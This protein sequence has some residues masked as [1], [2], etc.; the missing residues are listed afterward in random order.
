MTQWGD[1]NGS[2]SYDASGQRVR[3][4]VNNQETWQIYGLSGELLA[5]YPANGDTSNPQKEYGYRNGQ[6]LVTAVPV[7][8]TRQ[9]F[10][11]RSNGGSA[12]A[13]SEI[14]G[15]CSIWPARGAI[16]G[17]RKGSY[18][19][20]NGGWADSSSGSFS[21]DWFQVDF[22][23]AKTI[24]ELD[25]F[26]LQD[27]YSNPTE[28]TEAMTFSTYGLTAY[29]VS[30]WNGSAWINIPEASVVANNKVWRKFTFSPITTTKIRVLPQAAV[31]NGFSRLT[32]VEAWGS[33]NLPT[34]TNV[35]LRSNGGV[36]TA[37]SEISA[38][39]DTWP[40]RGANDGDRKGAYW[41]GTGGWAD[42]SSGN[43]SND[44]LQIDFAG[45]KTI[46]EIDVFTLQ[47]NYANPIEPTDTTT[48]STYGLTAFDVSYWNGS[49]W[50]QIPETVVTGN[51]KVWRKLTF[52]AIT[53][54]KIR[55]FGRAA[56]DNGRSRIA[57]LEAWSPTD[58]IAGTGVQW[59]IMD[60]LGTPRMLFDESGELGHIKRHDYLPFGEE[61]PA[62]AI[63]T[64]D[65]GYSVGDGVRQG[66]TSKERD[67][68][69]GLDYF[70]A[71]YY[72]S[73][74]GRFSSP[75][76]FVG[77]P[78]E[79]FDFSA[80]AAE[81]PTFYADLTQPQSLNKYQYCLNDPLIYVDP[82]GHQQVLTQR[83]LIERGYFN[84]TFKSM[85]ATVDKLID[86][87]SH[88]LRTWDEIRDEVRKALGTDRESIKRR[89]D[90]WFGP[91][92]PQY[93]QFVDVEFEL[94]MPMGRVETVERA[95]V[96]IVSRIGE[97]KR[98]V[99]LAEEA[100][101]SVQ[102][103]IDHL[104]SQLAAGNFNPG[105]GTRN[106]FGNISYART[107]DGAR[108]F[109]RRVGEQ[110]EIL[111]KSNKKNEPAVIDRLKKLYQR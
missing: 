45:S 98:I 18:W 53:T 35:A 9:N 14:S 42:S 87:G 51:N 21:N 40:A 1:P 62:Q 96:R 22:D 74:Q 43:F 30:Y 81:N 55:V 75:D 37:S 111:A 29:S 41:G 97:D 72:S 99:K 28:P 19:G 79:L 11:L 26:T 20:N 39:C 60:H 105:L 48:F 71:R 61:L 67:S 16:D 90:R 89:N 5:E 110:I 101:R 106:L 56:V 69:T 88:P 95:G 104:T 83:T 6:L 46:D 63:R 93:Q 84:E 59:L 52:S 108:V 23:S 50:A 102:Q 7:Q 47:D 78:D 49:S 15:G 13:S 92:P 3:R 38:G 54:T 32:E 107:R 4:M 10:A 77:G 36:A 25:I 86:K 27:N 68:E 12:S 31:D 103:S 57:E 33:V 80:G 44:W 64:A 2:Y 85:G 70:L 17:D 34:K 76:E 65:Q 82:D 94:A 66:F 24:D 109:F 73:G 8:T 58:S 91:T 100:G